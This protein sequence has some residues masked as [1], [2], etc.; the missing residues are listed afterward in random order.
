ME[1]TERI[2]EHKFGAPGVIGRLKDFGFEPEFH[3][4]VVVSWGWTDEAKSAA[5]AANIHLWDFRQI[6]RDI[7]DSIRGQRSYFS[8]D[9]LRTINLFVRAL[10]D[11]KRGV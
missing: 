1:T 6:V 9:A 5:D 3:S 11:D 10:E 4:K 2:V 8:D 7:S